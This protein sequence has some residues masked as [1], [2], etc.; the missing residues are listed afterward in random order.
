MAASSTN[1]WG[2]SSELLTEARLLHAKNVTIDGHNDLP[3]S[4]KESCN[5]VLSKVDLRQPQGAV[6]RPELRHQYLHTDIQRLRAGGFSAQFW[7]VYVPTQL[8]GANAVEAKLKQIDSASTAYALFIRKLL[9]LPP[10][11]QTSAA[12]KS[13]KIASLCGAEGGHQIAGSLAVLSMYYKVGARDLTL[14]HHGGPGWA[15]AALD[16]ARHSFSVK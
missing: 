6:L 10:T 14:T 11:R 2:H 1:E 15:D 9:S 13:G 3:W 7:S 5:Y 12:S 4:L 8:R 16:E